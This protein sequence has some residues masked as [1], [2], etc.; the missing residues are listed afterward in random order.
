MAISAAPAGEAH[1]SIAGVYDSTRPVAVQGTVV[2]FEFVNPHPVLTVNAAADGEP[3]ELWRL[4]MDNR[5]ELSDIGISA[6]TFKP[7]DRVVVNGS[8]HRNEARRLYVRRLERP[9]DGFMYEQVG[10]RPRVK[11]AP[12]N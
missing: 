4:E 6:T 7:G 8:A 2:E 9:A 11:L 12:G 10:F 5:F 3:A 1:H